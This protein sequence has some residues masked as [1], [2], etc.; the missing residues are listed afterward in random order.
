MQESLSNIRSWLHK[1][2]WYAPFC[3]P[4][5]YTH[6]CYCFLVAKSNKSRA[7]SRPKPE[8][9]NLP[10]SQLELDAHLL[11]MKDC[12]IDHEKGMSIIKEKI[13]QFQKECAEFDATIT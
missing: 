11:K 12:G 5:P 10:K 9:Y 4:P 8:D 13:H 6:N 1:I 2:I 3:P 7:V